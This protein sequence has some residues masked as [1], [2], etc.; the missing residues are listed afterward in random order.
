MPT[1]RRAGEWHLP[2]IT[3]EDRGTAE[4][5]GVPGILQK[6][7]A[8]RCARVSYLNHDGKSPDRDADLNLF[9]RLAGSE[10]MH[11]SPLEHVARPLYTSTP[12]RNFYGWRSVRADWEATVGVAGDEPEHYRGPYLGAL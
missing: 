2:Y 6:M 9:E 11:A 7:S 5:T 10:P 4:A 8:A 12:S 3:D 1:M